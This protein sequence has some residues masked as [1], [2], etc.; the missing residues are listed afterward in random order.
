[1]HDVCLELSK[2]EVL[3]MLDLQKKSAIISNILQAQQIILRINMI[4][5]LCI[6]IVLCFSDTKINTEPKRRGKSIRKIGLWETILWDKNE[7]GS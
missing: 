5:C 3:K 1:M 6:A 4:F 2:I 7:L